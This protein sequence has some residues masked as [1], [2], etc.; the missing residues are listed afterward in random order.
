MFPYHYAP[1]MADLARYCGRMGGR[2]HKGVLAGPVGMRRGLGCTL[3][4][5][6]E[7]WAPK[8]GPVRPLLQ[9]MS[10]LPPRR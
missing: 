3:T 8:D 6:P 10:V 2:P 1:L 9:L 4:A 7:E 5:S